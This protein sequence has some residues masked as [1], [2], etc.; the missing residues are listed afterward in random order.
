[1]RARTANAGPCPRRVWPAGAIQGKDE[2]GEKKNSP[3]SKKGEVSAPAKTKNAAWRLGKRGNGRPQV[4]TKGVRS[5]IRRPI[6]KKKPAGPQNLAP[7][8]AGLVD[9][10]TGNISGWYEMV[11]KNE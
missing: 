7:G 5:Q 6:P 9:E 11:P 1:L 8:G 4:C 3:S 10:N 2:F